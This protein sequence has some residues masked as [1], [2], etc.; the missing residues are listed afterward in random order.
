[1]RQYADE[2]NPRV[3]NRTGHIIRWNEDG[4]PAATTFTWDIF[5]FGGRDQQHLKGFVPSTGEYL[6]EENYFASPDGLLYDESGIL[7]IQTDM[8]SAQQ[9]GSGPDGDFGNN[10][11]LAAIP[12]TGEIKRFLVGPTDCEV[13]GVT[14]TPDH[15]TMFINIQ[16]PGDRS[17]PG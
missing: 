5:V 4:E 15:K 16:H 3:L 8:S 17:E 12:E 7:W 10:Q 9:D 11:M 2:A 6:D 1:G 13:T 14:L